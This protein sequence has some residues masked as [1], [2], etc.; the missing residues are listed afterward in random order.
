M[1]NKKPIPHVLN[2]MDKDG[3]GFTFP[4]SVNLRHDSKAKWTVKMNESGTFTFYTKMITNLFLRIGND[5]NKLKSAPL[6]QIV[7]HLQRCPIETN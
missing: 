4:Y 3:T 1:C 7:F 5:P 6:S 2:V